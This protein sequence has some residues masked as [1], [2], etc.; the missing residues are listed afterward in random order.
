M[1]ILLSAA[2]RNSALPHLA[3]GFQPRVNQNPCHSETAVAVSKL[4][5]VFL[6]LLNYFAP[7]VA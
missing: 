2:A 7:P 4:L 6:P 5:A 3:L 1:R